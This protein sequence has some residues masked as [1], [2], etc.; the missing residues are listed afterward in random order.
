MDVFIIAEIYADVAYI[1]AGI[2]P[3]EHE[4]APLKIVIITDL[5]PAFVIGVAPC[6]EPAYVDAELL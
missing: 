4:I 1:G 3:V 2:V 6:I 5:F